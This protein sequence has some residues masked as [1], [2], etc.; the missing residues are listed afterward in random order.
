MNNS[1]PS[2][3][4]SRRAATAWA[5]VNS[6]GLLLV[7]LL[8]LTYT[9]VLHPE[10]SNTARL[11]GH[12]S[13]LIPLWAAGYLLAAL[14]ILWGFVG[15]STLP[16]I[17]GLILLI[18]TSTVRY[19]AVTH[20]LMVLNVGFWDDR[21]MGQTITFIVVVGTS[22]LRLSVLLSRDGLTVTIPPLKW[23]K[24]DDDNGS[25]G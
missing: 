14:F 5:R 13:A 24:E 4:K 17:V 9:D 10:T 12:P 20:R 1:P 21:M 22:L 25:H 15:S 11:L 2:R 18:F 23:R 19:L 7:G 6:Y 16:E 3:K 8:V